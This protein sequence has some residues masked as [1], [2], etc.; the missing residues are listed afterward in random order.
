MKSLYLVSWEK[1]SLP[2]RNIR[3][4]ELIIDD[5]PACYHTNSMRDHAIVKAKTEAEAIIIAHEDRKS[6]EI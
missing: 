4:K 3:A 1:H 6:K 2:I 5:L